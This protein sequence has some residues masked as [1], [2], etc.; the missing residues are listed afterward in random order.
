[1]GLTNVAVLKEVLGLD[2]Y[3]DEWIQTALFA[4]SPFGDFLAVSSATAMVMYIKKL[5]PSTDKQAF[6]ILRTHCCSAENDEITAIT[7]LPVKVVAQG[8]SQDLWHCVVVGHQVCVM[9]FALKITK[10]LETA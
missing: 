2:T 3:Q 7:Y 8:R 9:P 10:N 5:V 6:Q 4:T 1:M